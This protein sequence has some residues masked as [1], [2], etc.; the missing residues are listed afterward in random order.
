[1][2]LSAKIYWQFSNLS[3]FLLSVGKSTHAEII[4]S[5]RRIGSSYQFFKILLV[6]IVFFLMNIIQKRSSAIFLVVSA[7]YH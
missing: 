6:T 5:G 4:S 1:M 2:L 7:S 3:P